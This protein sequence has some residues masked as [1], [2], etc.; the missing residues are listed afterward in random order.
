MPNHYADACKQAAGKGQEKFFAKKPDRTQR[1]KNF[2]N[3]AKLANISTAEADGGPEEPDSDAW[4]TL[5]GD[6]G[7]EEEE[8]E[9]VPVNMIFISQT[10]SMP[11]I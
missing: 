1:A 2:F 8:E 6:Q 4:Y 9:D 3:S 7:E 11:W 5:E 10:H